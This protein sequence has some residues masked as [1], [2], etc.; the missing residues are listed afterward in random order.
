M[1]ISETNAIR[2]KTDGV[3]SHTVLSLKKIKHIILWVWFF[4]DSSTSTYNRS[5]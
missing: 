2:V 4:L 1:A 5:P 3:S